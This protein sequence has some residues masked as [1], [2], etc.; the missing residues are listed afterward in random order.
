[1]RASVLDETLLT[2]APHAGPFNGK[3]QF[4][5]SKLGL[6]AGDVVRYWAVA[7]DNKSPAPNETVTPMRRIRVVAA[8]NAKQRQTDPLAHNEAAK[9]QTN[10]A[11]QDT[12]DEGRGQKSD[13][14]NRDSTSSQTQDQQPQDA[15]KNERSRDAGNQQQGQRPDRADDSR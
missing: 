5:P 8:E 2:D 13:Q 1:D 6:K 7:V 15:Q 10:N 9:N 11:P 14:Q 3:Y 12:R 4:I